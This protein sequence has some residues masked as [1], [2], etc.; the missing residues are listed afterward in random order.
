MTAS[1][2]D[3]VRQS[4]AETT[5]ERHSSAVYLDP[6]A[7]LRDA[8][9]NVDMHDGELQ[10]FLTAAGG[11]EEAAATAVRATSLWR[12]KRLT[13]A[14]IA[15]SDIEARLE[16]C[17][18]R[19]GTSG[20]G[21][22]VYCVQPGELQPEDGDDSLPSEAL[23]W[24]AR[25]GFERLRSELRD[26]AADAE[27]FTLLL[28]LRSMRLGFLLLTILPALRKLVHTFE[29]HYPGLLRCLLVDCTAGT[30]EHPLLPRPWTLLRPLLSDATVA[31]CVVL[32]EPHELLPALQERVSALVLATPTATRAA[33]M[34]LEWLLGSRRPC[35]PP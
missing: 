10:R 30:L 27:G 17:V 33:T 24:V 13:G 2:T 4:S 5:T 7:S 35:P 29:S 11:D 16:A 31:T 23:A 20:G 12:A 21:L 6:L 18:S 9:G 1:V 3:A 26:H 15:P 8:A 25:L 28:D 32:T 22:P 34:R 14:E 19:I